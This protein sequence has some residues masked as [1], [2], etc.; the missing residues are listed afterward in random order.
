MIRVERSHRTTYSVANGAI[1]ASGERG[2][3][4]QCNAL[5]LQSSPGAT[6]TAMYD[7][8][9]VPS[10]TA[11]GDNAGTDRR[12]ASLRVWLKRDRMQQRS[13][14]SD[15]RHQAS[16][17]ESRQR[18]ARQWQALGHRLLTITPR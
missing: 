15:A 10:F 3:I 16:L 18:A 9:G 5:W 6:T 4:A 11:S 7:L 8:L 12:G 2:C 14:P 1:L 17:A 13:G